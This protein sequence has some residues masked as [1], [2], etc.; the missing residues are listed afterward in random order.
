MRAT[1][2]EQTK[3]GVLS[4]VG[5]RI[6]ELR[7]GVG[8]TQDELAERAGMATRDLARI[9]AGGRNVTVGTLVRIACALGVDM[10]RLFD[11]PTTPR[12]GA[13]RPRKRR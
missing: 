9:E 1:T 11:P 5:A 12:L 4:A 2:I 7:R 3:R 13:G 8:V 6:G 10:A